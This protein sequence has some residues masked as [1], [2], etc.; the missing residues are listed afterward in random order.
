MWR[1][2]RDGFSQLQW[3]QIGTITP[4]RQIRI[5]QRETALMRITNNVRVLRLQTI[6]SRKHMIR[7][8]QSYLRRA[9]PAKKGRSF[10][11]KLKEFNCLIAVII[12]DTRSKSVKLKKL[13]SGTKMKRRPAMTIW[14]TVWWPL[15][16]IKMVRILT[17]GET[18]WLRKTCPMCKHW[19]VHWTL[20]LI[21]RVIGNSCAKRS[22]VDRD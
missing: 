13:H 4:R 9:K 18:S 10:I 21:R 1:I 6:C 19:I 22:K 16:L 2:G 20:Q 7:L 3:A 5:R 11:R 8:V 15:T 12:I 17:V 14:S